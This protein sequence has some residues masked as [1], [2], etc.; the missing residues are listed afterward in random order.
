MS[1][2]NP[3][4]LKHHAKKRL[5]KAFETSQYLGEVSKDSLDEY[6]QVE[7]EAYVSQMSAVYQMEVKKFNEALDNLLKAKIIYEK[8]A[9]YKDTLEAV[10]YTEKVT[11]LDTLIRLCAF[12]LQGMGAA[13]SEEE[14][15]K[16]MINS[17]PHRK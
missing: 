10:I 6:Q 7:V 4:R 14:L 11:Q 1:Q 13:Q 8:I 2:R 12:N 5:H 9:Q 17:Y 3:N 15:I 16:K